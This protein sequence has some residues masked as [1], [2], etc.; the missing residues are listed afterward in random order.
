MR[1]LLPLL[2]INAILMMA[3]ALV[4]WLAPAHFSAPP[5]AAAH[6]AFAQGVMPLILAAIA[7]FVP[8][9]TRGAGATPWLRLAPLLAWVGA[10]VILAGFTGRIDLHAAS[11]AAALFAGIA[12]C[13]MQMWMIRRARA[14]VGAAHPGLTW[15]LAAVFFLVAALLAVPAM[16]LWPEQ[17]AVLRQFHLHANLLGFVG[18][19]AI[20]T[21]QVLLPTSVGSFDRQASGRLRVDFKFACVGAMLLAAGAALAV[22]GTS[23][24]WARL[25]AVAGALLFL[26]APLR[27]ATYWVA[28]YREHIGSLHGAAASLALACLGLIGLMFAGI[29]H[30]LGFFAGRDAVAGF[31]L[32]FLLPLVSGA[33]T[34][35]LPVWL[36]PGIQGE[37]HHRL[38]S[39]L[40]RLGGLRALL[41]V[42]GGLAYAFGWH[43][44]IWLTLAG[45]AVLLVVAAP[46]LL[47][48]I[49]RRA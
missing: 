49:S 28:A 44:G 34:Q 47:F 39:R 31:V 3:A 13:A 4:M 32:A 48:A 40:G 12:A 24:E 14:A 26:V 1:S 43:G 22:P 45:V 17:R 29:G 5:Q 19:T 36:S 23:P 41:M 15:Y 18:L 30:T 46:P 27:M 11:I 16:V 10:A 20:G 25:V 21:L 9:L 6:L 7:Y 42:C 8:V 37:W 35:L 38:R 2:A 33:A